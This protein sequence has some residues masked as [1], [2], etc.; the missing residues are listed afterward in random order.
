MYLAFSRKPDVIGE[1]IMATSSIPSLRLLHSF[2]NEDV[3]LVLLL[4]LAGGVW[5]I[6]AC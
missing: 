5:L 2:S 1:I 3:S 4:L 6:V